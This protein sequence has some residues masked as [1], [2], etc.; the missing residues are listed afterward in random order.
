MGEGEGTTLRLLAVTMFNT[1]LF[2]EEFRKKA[3][4]GES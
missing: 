4:E 3:T 2:K 1:V